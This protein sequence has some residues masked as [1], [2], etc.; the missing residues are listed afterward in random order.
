MRNTP[1]V[2]ARAVIPLA[3]L[4]LV[5]CGNNPGNLI[6]DDPSV[7]QNVPQASDLDGRWV[8]TTDLAGEFFAGCLTIEGGRATVFFDGCGYVNNLLTSKPIAFDSVGPV[9][10]FSVWYPLDD[11]VFEMTLYGTARTDD[12]YDVLIVA[13]DGVGSASIDGQME[14]VPGSNGHSKRWGE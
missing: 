10:E 12:F 8:L 6:N 9:I 7:G 4:L 3:G 5:G 14:R 11:V 2:C 1:N 13:D